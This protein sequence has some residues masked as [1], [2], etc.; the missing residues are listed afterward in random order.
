MRALLME[1]MASLP[2]FVKLLKQ[3]FSDHFQS[4][5][6]T[7]WWHSV[8]GIAFTACWWRILRRRYARWG[9]ISI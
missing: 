2:M 7:A 4:F 1:R 5:R 8:G 3:R 6:T 9:L